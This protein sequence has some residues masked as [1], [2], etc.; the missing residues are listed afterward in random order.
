MF[1]GVNIPRKFV[2][3]TLTNRPNESQSTRTNNS[4]RD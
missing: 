4:D 2:E 3:Q 1:G